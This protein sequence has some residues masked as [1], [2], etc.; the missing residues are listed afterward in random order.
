MRQSRW[1]PQRSR[2]G[3]VSCRCFDAESSY[4]MEVEMAQSVP[5][6]QTR[7]GSAVEAITFNFVYKS[8]NYNG[9]LMDDFVTKPGSAGSN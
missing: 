8:G 3:D 1:N 5:S 7:A 4:E 6:F 9:P 2:V